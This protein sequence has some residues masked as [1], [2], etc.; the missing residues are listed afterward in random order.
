MAGHAGT[1]T[2]GQ[3]MFPMQYVVYNV[4]FYSSYIVPTA[5]FVWPTK[6]TTICYKYVHLRHAW[7]S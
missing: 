1:R 4:L 5:G 3:V 2:N 7:F 6:E